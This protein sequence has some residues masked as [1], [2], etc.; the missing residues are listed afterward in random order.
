MLP[1]GTYYIGDPCYVLSKEQW[2]EVCEAI[3]QVGEEQFANQAL[4]LMIDNK[5]PIGIAPTLYGDGEFHISGDKSLLIPVDSGT[6][7]CVPIEHVQDLEEAKELGWV[8]EFN[9]P[10]EIRYDEGVIRFGKEW[11]NT[12]DMGID[13]DKLDIDDLDVTDEDDAD[14]DPPYSRF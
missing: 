14:F 5:F 3:A 12:T 11:V 8:T 2:S 10:F 9:E 7:G 1:A 6:I 13:V 4:E